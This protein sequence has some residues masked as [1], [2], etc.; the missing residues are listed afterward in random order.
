MQRIPFQEVHNRLAEVLRALGFSE[1]RA[2]L[3]ARLFAETT[4]DGVYSHGVNRFAR[5][6]A[7]VRNG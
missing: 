4:C 2:R 3:S 7:M 6:V 1:E 5:F